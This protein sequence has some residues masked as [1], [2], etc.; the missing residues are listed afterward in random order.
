MAATFPDDPGCAARDVFP[1]AAARDDAQRGARALRRRPQAAAVYPGLAAAD[2][3][4]VLAA[5][6][7]G[8]REKYRAAGRDSPSA[9]GRDFRWAVAVPMAEPEDELPERQARRRPAA[10][11]PAVCS[12]PPLPA[13]VAW[14]RAAQ[15][16][17]PGEWA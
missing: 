7:W 2:E 14:L 11:Q 9:G 12:E 10:P 16:Q 15:E 5:G 13:E 1:S 4:V 3:S 6:H 17:P 8:V